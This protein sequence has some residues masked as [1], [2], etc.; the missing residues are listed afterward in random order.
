VLSTLWVVSYLALGLPAIGAGFL[1]VDGGGLL[2]TAREVGVAVMV[3]AVL[4]MIG[5]ARGLRGAARDPVIRPADRAPLIRPAGKAPLPAGR[6]APVSPAD[7]ASAAG[8][9]TG[10]PRR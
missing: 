7:R 10:A 2:S 5:L 3:L 8:Q 1:V 4:A 6:A 9:P